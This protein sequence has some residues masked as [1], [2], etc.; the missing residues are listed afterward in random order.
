MDTST[1]MCLTFIFLLL[2][3][4]LITPSSRTKPPSAH[5]LR[6]PPGPWQLPLIG[7]LHHLLLSPLRD[8]PHRA[9]LHMSKTHSPLMLLRLG[10]VPTLVASSV[11]A[12]MEVMRTH[13]AAFCSRHLSAT[14]GIISRGGKGIIFSHYGDQ[15]RDLRKVCVLELFSPRR[16]LAF[17]HVREEEAARLLRSLVSV[18]SGGGNVVVDLGEAICRMVNDVVVRTAVGG[19]RCGRRDEFLRELDEAVRLTGGF[20]LADL[21]SSSRLARR[22]SAAAR[23]MERCQGKVYGIIESIIHERAVARM[24]EREEDDDLLGVLLRLQR[25][26]GLQFH[27]TNE[28]S[29]NLL[30]DTHFGANLLVDTGQSAHCWR[31]LHFGANLLEDTAASQCERREMDGR[32]YPS[33]LLSRLY[34]TKGGFEAHL[35]PPGSSSSFGRQGVQ[36]NARAG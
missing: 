31:T 20:N 36:V 5:H 23:G 35:S 28:I 6:L 7:S 17:R 4:K 27:L 21:Y 13:D 19:R 30:V 18:I 16:V 24:P 11:E 10:S 9:L 26:G 32:F 15:W 1:L 3:L 25:E 29:E 12:A 14:I 8:L 34:C 33:L 22:I 2:L